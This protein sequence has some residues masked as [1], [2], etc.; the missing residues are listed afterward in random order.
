MKTRL[1]KQ[2][3]IEQA[4]AERAN[5]EANLLKSQ[6]LGN[7]RILAAKSKSALMTAK[8]QI[9]QALKSHNPADHNARFHATAAH[10]ELSR[11]VSYTLDIAKILA[12]AK[13]AELDIHDYEWEDI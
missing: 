7:L 13:T 1:E 10:K 9:E 4:I 5:A 8:L 3:E 12:Q 11:Y 6:S 2:K